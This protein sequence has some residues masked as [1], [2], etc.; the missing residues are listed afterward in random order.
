MQVNLYNFLAIPCPS[1]LPFCDV[2]K[3]CILQRFALVYVGMLPAEEY[4][5]CYS[6]LYN[7]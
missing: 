2:Q 3:W 5:I 1:S 4:I 7:L 6:V